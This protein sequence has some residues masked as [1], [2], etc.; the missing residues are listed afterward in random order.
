MNQVLDVIVDG[1]NSVKVKYSYKYGWPIDDL[2]YMIQYN[3][4]PPRCFI[5]EISYLFPYKPKGAPLVY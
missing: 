4:K 3:T 2:S 1:L 5:D